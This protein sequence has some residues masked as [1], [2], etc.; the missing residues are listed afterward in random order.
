MTSGKFVHSKEMNEKQSSR[1]KKYC[2]EHPEFVEKL[3]QAN[4]GIN[5]TP[6]QK[7][8]QRQALLGRHWI[9]K[10]KQTN[11]EY[12]HQLVLEKRKKLLEIKNKYKNGQPDKFGR[13]KKK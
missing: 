4:L 6:E 7:E 5:R 3:R 2:E 13:P 9:R 8:R 11:E 1:M 10:E 12:L